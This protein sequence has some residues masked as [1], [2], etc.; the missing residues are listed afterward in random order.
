MAEHPPG[1]PPELEPW[2]AAVAARLGLEVTVPSELLLELTR[3][4]A[5]RVTRPAGP[6]TTYLIGLAV[7]G[8]A[9][10]A[11]AVASVRALLDERS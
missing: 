10:V 1:L 4:T 9:D 3:E 6:I 11:D 7:A 5:H 8:G 2:A